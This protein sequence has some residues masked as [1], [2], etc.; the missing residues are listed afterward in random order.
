MDLARRLLVLSLTACI[1]SCGSSQHPPETALGE[2]TGTIRGLD[3]LPIQ[4]AS[5]VPEP[6]DSLLDVT[7]STGTYRMA[8][9]AGLYDIQFGMQDVAK[10]HDTI[11]VL[12]GQVVTHDVVL[13]TLAPAHLRVL[14]VD[15]QS[16]PVPSAQVTI[17]VG[18]AG[19]ILET[20]AS[21]M[22]QDVVR[23]GPVRVSAW[24]T[25]SSDW[26]VRDSLSLASGERVTL[27]LQMEDAVHAPVVN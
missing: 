11:T 22:V 9:P 10:L 24:R 19:H 14:V 20:D 15:K 27:R 18:G 17:A 12:A 3:Q 13:A 25:G 4:G 16:N 23:P 6:H 1:S 8:L 26:Q 5:A 2:V 21:G 7:D